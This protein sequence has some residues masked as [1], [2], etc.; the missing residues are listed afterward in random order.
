MGKKDMTKPRWLKRSEAKVSEDRKRKDVSVF[1]LPDPC[2][3]QSFAYNNVQLFVIKKAIYRL[4]THLSQDTTKET[5]GI[6]VGN[7]EVDSQKDIYRT[8]IISAIA[9]PTTIGNRSTFRFTPH[10][11][12]AILKEQKE[13]YPQTQ[14]VGWYHSHPNF[15]VFLSGVDIETQQDCFNQPW[16]IAVV[17]DPIRDEIGFFCGAKGEKMKLVT[18]ENKSG[19]LVPKNLHN[20]LVQS[21]ENP[22]NVDAND[23]LPEVNTNQ[24][25]IN[26][27]L[28]TENPENINLDDDNSGYHSSQNDINLLSALKGI[29]IGFKIIFTNSIH[30]LYLLRIEIIKIFD[31]NLRLFKKLIE[32]VF[33]L[34]KGSKE[35]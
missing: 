21:T 14:I 25:N 22:Q 11:W 15:G 13:F 24:N 20:Y 3:Y 35:Q 1:S 34:F 9:A 12:S 32:K 28:S 4:K 19:A 6:L 30:L 5:G 7:V 33:N 10:C 26:V 31:G 2:Q 23:D 16:H 29:F 17:Y 18:P 8:Q 27:G